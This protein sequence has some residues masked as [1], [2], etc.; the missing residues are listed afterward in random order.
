MVAVPMLPHAEFRRN[1]HREGAPHNFEMSD[2]EIAWFFNLPTFLKNPF[3]TVTITF[4]SPNKCSNLV[5]FVFLLCWYSRIFVIMRNESCMCA[6]FRLLVNHVTCAVVCARNS[7][8]I[9]LAVDGRITA[10]LTAVKNA[11]KKT[12]IGSQNLK[13]S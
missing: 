2:F 13:I 12:K 10:V 1:D 6:T 3:F 8:K 7:S 11:L 5:Y 4:H 9:L